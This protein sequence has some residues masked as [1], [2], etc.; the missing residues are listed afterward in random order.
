MKDVEYEKTKVDEVYAMTEQGL[1]TNTQLDM[2]LDRLKMIQQMHE[3]S[4]NLA[5]QISNI[6]DANKKDVPDALEAEKQ[7]L[8]KTQETMVSQLKSIQGLV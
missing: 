3:Q 5:L 2:M 8:E 1:Q 6:R 7:L 4:P